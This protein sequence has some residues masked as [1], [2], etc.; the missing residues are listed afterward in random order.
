MG[1]SG[2][3]GKGKGRPFKTRACLY[4]IQGT[5]TKGDSCTFLHPSKEDGENEEWN[6]E[7][8][9]WKESDWGTPYKKWNR[10]ELQ[11]EVD[12]LLAEGDYKNRLD[13]LRSVITRIGVK[14]N[15]FRTLFGCTII[16]YAQRYYKHGKR[17]DN[18]EMDE[19]LTVL[20]RGRRAERA[21]RFKDDQ[22]SR[23][24]RPTRE[25]SLKPA[26]ITSFGDDENDF[27]DATGNFLVVGTSTAL[28]KE[29]LRL[30]SAPDPA[31][32]RPLEVLRRSL[33]HIK[34]QISTKSVKWI[35]DQFKAIRQDL[36]VQHIRNEFTAEV[37]ATHARVA[38]QNNDLGHFNQ[39]QSKLEGL[40]SDPNIEIEYDVKI[41]FMAYRML[42]LLHNKLRFDLIKFMGM[43]TQEERHHPTLKWADG[44]RSAYN[45]GNWRRYFRL[46]KEAPCLG[47][48]LLEFFISNV[49][50]KCLEQIC[51]SYM[52]AS[53]PFLQEY[54][55]MKSED[56]VK[57]FLAK[58]ASIMKDAKSLDCKK[59][60]PKI[61]ESALFKQTKVKAMG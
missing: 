41:E 53:I 7:W 33:A 39:C 55:N 18:L 48:D 36:T 27:M 19:E 25:I 26:F 56:E 14:P 47:K 59:S 13:E 38:L 52:T 58:G 28:E 50:A 10:A 6:Q 2:D 30:T 37:Y 49:R 45:L 34:T 24:A 40:H 9:S 23:A 11:T 8:D 42:Y 35:G 22:P 54:L 3:K 60:L 15:Y 21:N 5:C 31:T 51:K 1:D 43:I 16:Q 20:E 46:F 57:E 29:Y 17:E 4:F 44:I 61:R 32:V 12:S